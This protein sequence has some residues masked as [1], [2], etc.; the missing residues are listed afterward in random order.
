MDNNAGD[1]TTWR[2]GC[3]ARS[4]TLPQGAR[5]P[6]ATTE[7]DATAPKTG[8]FSARL[9]RVQRA[10]TARFISPV[11]SS[12]VAT[13]LLRQHTFRGTSLLRGQPFARMFAFLAPRRPRSIMWPGERWRC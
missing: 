1:Y 12:V 11:L 13:S 5:S 7:C 4:P 8:V 6:L 3:Q 2:M 9:V 10:S